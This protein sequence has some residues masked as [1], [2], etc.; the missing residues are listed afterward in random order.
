MASPSSCPSA[1]RLRRLLADA[2]PDP[3]QAE[4]LAHVGACAACQR[5]LDQLAG[6]NP[7]VLAVASTLH[8]DAY[9][10]EPTL[11]RVLDD[12]GSD[13]APT[14]LHP[15]EHEATWLEQLLEPAASSD[16][17]GQLA[18]YEVTEVLGRGGMG[19][20]L[21]AFDRGL[22]RPVAIKV[23]ARDLAGD[24]VA[25][26]RF[27]R[28]A[29]AAAGVRHEQVITIHAVGE[30]RGLP[31]FVMEYV[32]GGSLQDYLDCNGPPDWR[33]I[34]RL[35]AEIASGLAATH[36]HGL[37]HRDI[38][39]SNILLEP[40]DDPGALGSAKIGDFGLVRAGDDARL[41][42]T[43]VI[44][45]TPMYMA[46]E[47]ALC[48]NL[49]A[50]ADLFSLGSVLY[51][52]CTGREP[53]PDGSAVA[54]LHQVCEGTPGPIREMNP[55]IPPWLAATV[56]R[57]HAKVPGD[58]FV[59]AAEVAELLRY[60]LAHPDRPR[61]VPPPRSAPQVRRRR[62]RLLA[63]AGLGL[64]LLVGG[65]VL[66]ESLGRLHPAGG[67]VE[68]GRVPLRATLRGYDGPVWSVAFAPDGK[69]VVTGSDDS[70]LR[71]WD[72]GTGR[73]QESLRT[74]GGIVAV[75]FAHSG[76]FL[77][78]GD[79]DGNL[80]LWD[81]ATHTELPPLPHHSTNVRRLAISPDDRTLAVGGGAQGV[82]LWDL[83]SRTVRQMLPGHQ[84]TVLAVVF[85][86]DGKTLATGDASGQVR[87]WDP[88]TGSERAHF[89]GDS[90]NLR[91]LA[92]TPDS[93]L[94][95]SAGTGDLDVK[96][97]DVA[98]QTRV[99]TLCGYENAL[100]NVTISHDGRLLATG[101]RDGTVKVWDVMSAEARATLRAH[102]GSVLGVA[103]AP[104]GRTLATVGEDRL[105]KLWDLGG[106]AAALP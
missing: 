51:A 22:K 2:P 50:R 20:V 27:A 102:Q 67:A 37:I 75:A 76:K 100:V 91:A 58:R 9:L 80:S 10:E 103:F 34:A 39:P 13:S 38:K 49:D 92:F 48:R 105:G 87:L 5:L 62:R 15:L 89:G 16:N 43:G 4:L 54:V 106:L 29:Q 31:Y 66:G 71:F 65:L 93:R 35:G 77:V 74:R 88:A 55:T 60:N 69:T 6:A 7:T 46:P 28:E 18:D 97:W 26:Q 79:G 53:F 64:L 61:R 24:P 90:L 96:L 47:Q 41:T 99:A 52:L 11:R 56:E 84:G 40:A 33:V 63:A 12:L 25:R 59:S 3:D 44:S 78:S 104:D 94:L 83:A 70:T 42:R 36:A 57:L 98:T 30:V 45:G 68:D 23:L 32:E 19:L 85:A 73:A 1:D 95:A 14:R 101:S 86:P 17:L 21:K 8:Q 81:A 82:E 72:A